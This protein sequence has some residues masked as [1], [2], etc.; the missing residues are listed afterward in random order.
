MSDQSIKPN[1]TYIHNPSFPEADNTT[2]IQNPTLNYQSKSN[3][4]GYLEQAIEGATLGDFSDKNTGAKVIG[5]TLAGLIPVYGQVGDFRDSTAAV[6]K[7][8]NGE[9]GGWK[10]L[11][12]SAIGWVPG[13]GDYVKGV[14]KGGKASA[15]AAKSADAIIETGLKSTKAADSNITKAMFDKEA[16]N[17]K[18]FYKPSVKGTPDLPKGIGRTD[19]NGDI[20]YSTRGTRA[21]QALAYHHEKVHSFF[22]PKLKALQNVRAKDLSESAPLMRYMEEAIAES[23]SQAKVNGVKNFAEGLKFPIKQGYVELKDVLLEGA[24]TTITIGNLHYGV[25]LLANESTDK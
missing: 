6:I 1:T 10:D 18:Y 13:V 25:H 17:G 22:S 16:V 2:Y 7:I 3:K 11:G 9:K 4:A 20:L 14:L 21:D 19:L 15:K 23:Y 8:K 5:Q 12:L 24:T